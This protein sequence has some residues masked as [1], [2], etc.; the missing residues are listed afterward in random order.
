MIEL[1][2]I[3][4]RSFFS[5]FHYSDLRGIKDRQIY[6][7]NRSTGT[8]HFE[9][10]ILRN[11]K[12]QILQTVLNF[13]EIAIDFSQKYTVPFF[14]PVV[15]LNPSTCTRIYHENIFGFLPCLRILVDRYCRKIDIS[16]E[17]AR[18]SIT[19][20]LRNFLSIASIEIPIQSFQL[21]ANQPHAKLSDLDLASELW[22]SENSGKRLSILINVD[23]LTGGFR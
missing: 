11:Q 1:F 16:F 19:S 18:L 22:E 7:T 15:Y 23:I 12:V 20:I 6:S 14:H 2:F 9:I 8:Y 13:L 10:F 4:L 5:L 3:F 17:K 21:A